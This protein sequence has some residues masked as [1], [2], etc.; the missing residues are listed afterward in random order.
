MIV[1]ETNKYV[2]E[3]D[4]IGDSGGKLVAEARL[5]HTSCHLRDWIDVEPGKYDEGRF[6]V[7][8]MIIRLLR[9]D[10]TVLREEDGAVGIWA[11]MFHS[12]FTSSPYWSI[13]TWVKFLHKWC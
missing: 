12:K 5:E 7:S 2:T 10:L 8:K 6:E 3:I 1:N 4:D 13:R 9:H 11:P